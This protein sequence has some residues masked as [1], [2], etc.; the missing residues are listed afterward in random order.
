MYKVETQDVDFVE[1]LGPYRVL[2]IL[3]LMLPS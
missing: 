1:I 2:E 3:L